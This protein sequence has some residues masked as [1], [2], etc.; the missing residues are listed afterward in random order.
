[1]VKKKICELA[2]FVDYRALNKITIPEK[3]PITIINEL[4]DELAGASI[5]GKSDLKSGYY[6]LRIR[7]EDIKKIAFRTHER[8]Y[9]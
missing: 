4:L 9:E 7:E 5:F 2:I 8:H 3:S 1:M 6:Q